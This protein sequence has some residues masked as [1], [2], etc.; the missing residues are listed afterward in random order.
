MN[1]NRWIDSFDVVLE[2]VRRRLKRWIHI[3]A[4]FAHLRIQMVSDGSENSRIDVDD[5]EE[6]YVFEPDESPKRKRNHSDRSR[7]LT[8]SGMRRSDSSL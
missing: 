7:A 8:I 2:S 1:G 3:F 6:D 4:S 5:D